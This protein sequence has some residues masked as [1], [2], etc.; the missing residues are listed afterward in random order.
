MTEMPLTI[1]RRRPL[2]LAMRRGLTGHCPA[3]GQGRLFRAY[4]KVVDSCEVCGEALHHQRADD[5]PAYLTLLIV[6][7]FIVAGVL[8]TEFVAPNSPFWLPALIWSA[9]ALVASLTL[10][11]RI[12]GALIGLQWANRMHGFGGHLD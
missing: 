4:L 5:A 1:E 9:L 10:L 8:A 11:P 2:G 12:K 6:G 7:H 3:C